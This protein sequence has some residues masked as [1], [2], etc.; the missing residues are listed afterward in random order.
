M[1]TP[2]WLWVWICWRIGG[3][4]TETWTG[5]I[6]GLNATAWDLTTPKCKLCQRRFKVGIGKKFVTERVIGHWDGLA[7][8]QSSHHPWRGLGRDWMWLSVPWTAWKAGVTSLFGLHDL[9]HRC[10]LW[11]CGIYYSLLTLGVNWAFVVNSQT[12]A[13]VWR[14]SFRLPGTFIWPNPCRLSHVQSSLAWLHF[15]CLFSPGARG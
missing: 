3:L 11:F 5:W 7:G 10:W 9:F 6:N 2:S 13:W 8:R 12:D 14:M 4:C 1:V 15:I